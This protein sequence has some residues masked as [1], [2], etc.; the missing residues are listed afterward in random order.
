MSDYASYLALRPTGSAL[1]GKDKGDIS[2]RL[3]CAGEQTVNTAKAVA[4]GGTILGAT[5]L[6][7]YGFYKSA[8]AA[9]FAAKIFN[10]IGKSAYNLLG[11][12]N[13]KFLE[14]AAK[15]IN[16]LP[17]TAKAIGLVT[18]PALIAILHINN[19]MLCQAGQIDQK[20][21]DKAN[22]EERLKVI[23]G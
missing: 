4:K 6:A 13:I 7:G 16:K 11:M 8:K 14:K 20:Y 5:T 1:L 2:N 9:S 21:S 3:K 22:M 19:K 17:P 23:M 15:T 10:K 12:N 18:L